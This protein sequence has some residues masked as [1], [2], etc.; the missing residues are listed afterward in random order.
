MRYT[1]SVAFGIGRGNLYLIPNTYLASAPG[2]ESKIVA[3]IGTRV[4]TSE[5][6]SSVRRNGFSCYFISAASR[7]TVYRS[8]LFPSKS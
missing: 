4:S 8:R 6:E 1:E 2:E 3:A 7:C 5:K